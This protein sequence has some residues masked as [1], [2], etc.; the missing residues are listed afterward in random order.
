MVQFIFLYVDSDWVE[1]FEEVMFCFVVCVEVVSWFQLVFVVVDNWNRVEV[2]LQYI[3]KD[4]LMIVSC[5]S[6]DIWV[7]DYGGIMVFEED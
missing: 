3:F 1:L 4:C 5:F 6:N 2:L 7:C